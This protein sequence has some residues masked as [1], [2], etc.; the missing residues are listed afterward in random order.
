MTME[1]RMNSPTV[2]LL[3]VALLGAVALAGCKKKDAAP[4]VPDAAPVATSAPPPPPPMP[5][6]APAAAP[7]TATVG[8]IELGNAIGADNRITTAMTTFA[9]HDTIYGTVTT[10][11]P[12]ANLEAHWTFLG[13]PGSN[14]LPTKVSTESIPMTG[15]ATTHAFHVSKPDGWP[16][17]RYRLEV[18]VSGNVLQTRDFEVR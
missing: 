11:A 14:A 13:A 3:A 6:E 5:T 17:G 8:A 9:P 4:V 10:P 2:R 16:V 1:M 15:A 18:S 7:A 12:T